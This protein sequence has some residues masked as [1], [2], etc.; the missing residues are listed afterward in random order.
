MRPLY[1]GAPFVRIP[2]YVWALIALLLGITLGGLLPAPLAPVAKG[3]RA[4]IDVIILLVPL[5]IFVA[6]SPAI[7]TLMRRGLAGRFAGAVIAWFILTTAVAGLFAILVTSIIF[8][9]RLS[10]ETGGSIERAVSILLEF[11]FGGSVSLPL[12]AILGAVVIGVVGAKAGRLYTV[13]Q[14]IERGIEQ[15]GSSISYFMA[16]LVLA[17]GIMIGVSFGALLGMSHYATVVIYSL[18]L[19]VA[20]WLFYVFVLLRFL[21]G[22]RS[23]GRL[24]KLYYIPTA[25]FAA[26]TCS[27][28]A[29]LPVNLASAKQYGVRDEV[30]D[31]VISIGAVANKDA[32]ALWNLACAPFVITYVFGLDMSWSLMLLAWPFIVLYTTAAP[33]LPAGMGASLWAPVLFASFLGLDDPLRA[34]FVGTWVAFAAGVP[35][36]FG[37]ATNAAD[38]GFTAVIFDHNFD[39][40]FARDRIRV[41]ANLGE[42]LAEGIGERA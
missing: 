35:D 3:V 15:V 27:S 40:H 17:F 34:T 21:G 16:P 12:L 29:T 22:V 37:T 42:P 8:R 26:G 23:P 30:A 41:P 2:A 19:N 24:L 31:F 18:F 13:L 9:A 25:L 4:L 5:L 32:S 11:G 10:G 36:M 7:A 20:W 33:G 38:D 14:R 39:K 6:L 28:Y 1:R